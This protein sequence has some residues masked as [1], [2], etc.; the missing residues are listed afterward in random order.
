[1]LS[2]VWSMARGRRGCRATT[3]LDPAV[4]LCGYVTQGAT[5]SPREQAQTQVCQP[6]QGSWAGVGQGR[7]KGPGKRQGVGNRGLKVPGVHALGYVLS[8]ACSSGLG[9][10]PSSEPTCQPQS[11]PNQ[12]CCQDHRRAAAAYSR[13]ATGGSG[14]SGDNLPPWDWSVQWGLP[15]DVL[16]ASLC[17]IQPL[18][19]QALGLLLS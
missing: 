15:C 4:R 8:S 9:S 5:P 16:C 19:G 7:A 12:H 18:K 10:H 6:I 11:S 1:M 14:R 3:W 2:G 17:S 13:G